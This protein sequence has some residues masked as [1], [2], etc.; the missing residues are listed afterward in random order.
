ML[1]LISVTFV[2]CLSNLC[3]LA[4]TEKYSAPV[5]WERY[6]I[7][8]KNVS[9]L[10]PKMP[11]LIQ[12]ADACSETEINRF[13]VYA[14]QTVY[15]L[16]LVSK[17]KEKAP[18]FCT[19]KNK[20]DENSF[21]ERLH[22]IKASLKTFEETKFNQN[23]LE[24]TKIKSAD[25]TYTYWFINDFKN[26]KWLELWTTDEEK[27]EAKKFIESIKIENDAQGIEIGKGA[28]RTLGD[29]NVVV[30][31]TDSQNKQIG[32]DQAKTEVESLRIIVKPNPKY[33]EAARQA[34]IQ[35]TVALRVT[36]LANGGIGNISPVSA[37]PYGLTEQAIAAASKIVFI[38][39]KKNG[40]S[41]SVSKILQYTFSIY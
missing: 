38:P 22:Q 25:K 10:F 3:I 11:V 9:V 29:E 28:S 31:N 26:K 27:A 16:T 41:H 7:S 4:Q 6:K 20:F 23:N 13:A 17:T 21:D 12:W 32:N 19:N 1:K 37:L 39:A 14:N 33:T 30:E 2:I 5:K 35:G 34:T 36:F 18:N 24:V 8:D 40:V 15:G